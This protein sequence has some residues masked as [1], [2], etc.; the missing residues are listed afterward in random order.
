MII[1]ETRTYELDDNIALL[2]LEL[3]RKGYITTFCCEG[4][5]D[6]TYIAFDRSTSMILDNQLPNNI[7]KY[8]S[9]VYNH[10]INW[11]IDRCEDDYLYYKM[12]IIRRIITDE[13]YLM[14]T[15]KQLTTMIMS[16][17]ADWIGSLPERYNDN[18]YNI[19]KF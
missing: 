10:P 8:G 18:E 17:L 7:K 13:E 19:I 5:P 4:H 16:E 11:I 15:D 1:Q 2:V 12:F 3:N 6:G 9:I 14:N